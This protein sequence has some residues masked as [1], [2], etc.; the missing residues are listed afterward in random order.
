MKSR[1]LQESEMCKST[2]R[3][4]KKLTKNPS[5]VSNP[6][7]QQCQDSSTVV[8]Q[9]GSL[10]RSGGE[11]MCGI[12]GLLLTDTVTDTSHLFS[13]HLF[14]YISWSLSLP[15]EMSCKSTL[16]R[17]IDNSSAPWTRSSIFQLL[18]QY[19]YFHSPLLPF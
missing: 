18:T 2:K 7:Q 15:V 4:S 9:C 13:F 17:W 3:P 14:Y 19:N 11:T 16:G 12:I 6:T 10:Q 8:L 1:Q 5:V